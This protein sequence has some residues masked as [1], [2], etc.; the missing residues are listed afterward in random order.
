MKISFCKPREQVL[1]TSFTRRR[2]WYR[3]FLLAAEILFQEGWVSLWR[4]VKPALK[5]IF[6][7]YQKIDSISKEELEDARTRLMMVIPT[8]EMGGA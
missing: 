2:L 3:R 7:I 8:M 4:Q 6:C 5:Q 1:T